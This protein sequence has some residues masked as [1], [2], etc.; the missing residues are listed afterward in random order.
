MKTRSTSWHIAIAAEAFAAG[1]FARCG[2]NV[3]VQYGANQPEYDLMIARG[4]AVLK[5]SV[6]GSQDGSWGLTQT[7]LTRVTKLSGQK[8]NYHSA[9]DAWLIRHGQ[10]TIFCLVQFKG[11]V[12]DQMPRVYLATPTDIALRL[13]ETAGGRGDTILY[14]EH[15]WGPH[16]RGA[17]TS[18]IIP[19]N[20]RLSPERLDQ[21]F[22]A[23]SGF[24]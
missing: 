5:V 2:C 7:E 23:V 21:L 11:V 20:W 17:G 6:K 8:A 19:A 1:L 13:K 14:E 3:S 24:V 18:E 15:H 9:I 12:L 22:S 4:D 16:A 10:R